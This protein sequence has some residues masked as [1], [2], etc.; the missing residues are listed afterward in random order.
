MRARVRACVS[1][2]VRVCVCVRGCVRVLCLRLRGLGAVAPQVEDPAAGRPLALGGGAA[3]VELALP[4]ALGSGRRGLK[5]HQDVVGLFGPDVFRPFHREARIV[6]LWEGQP[7]RHYVVGTPSHSAGFSSV[8]SPCSAADINRMHHG[9]F[10][11]GSACLPLNQDESSD[12]TF[13]I[14][15]SEG[16]FAG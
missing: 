11:L 8:R 7:R 6:Y 13:I 16:E 12:S 2:C 5:R 4:A 10:Q 1:V 3:D 15:H 14:V 9:I